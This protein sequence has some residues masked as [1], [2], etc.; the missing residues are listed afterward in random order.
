MAA[1]IQRKNYRIDVG[2]LNRAKKALGTKT[3]TET[4]HRALDMVADEA[5]YARALKALLELGPE[6]IVEIDAKR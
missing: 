4:I 2:K 3:E 6:S 5:G 1:R